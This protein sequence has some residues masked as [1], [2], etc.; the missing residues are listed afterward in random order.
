M[1]ENLHMGLR[2]NAIPTFLQYLVTSIKTQEL[3]IKKGRL[4]VCD[5]FMRL[6]NLDSFPTCL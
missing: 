6:K 3:E 5:S 1:R 2:R 4:R